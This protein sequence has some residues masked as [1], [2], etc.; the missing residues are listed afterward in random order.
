MASE[1]EPEPDV[2]MHLVDPSHMQPMRELMVCRAERWLAATLVPKNATCI[3][4][5][6]LAGLLNPEDAEIKEGFPL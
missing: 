3:E 5:L 1:R 6:L 4:C 2:V